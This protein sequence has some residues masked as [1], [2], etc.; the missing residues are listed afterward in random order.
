MTGLLV[1]VFAFFGLQTIVWLLRA[2]YVYLNDT[3]TFRE[4]KTKTQT[5]DEFFTRLCPSSASCISSW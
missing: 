1:G 3:K 5:D 2:V 4:A